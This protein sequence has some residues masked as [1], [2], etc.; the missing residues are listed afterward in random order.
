LQSW[1]PVRRVAELGSFGI[2]TIRIRNQMSA[3]EQHTEKSYAAIAYALGVARGVLSDVVDG[4]FDREDVRR[5]YEATASFR[6]AA[7]IEMKESD[8]SVN[9]NDYLSEAEKYK[10]Q[11]YQNAEDAAPNGGPATPLSNSGAVEGPPSVS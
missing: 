8:V 4:H 9:W 11:G 2:C 6:I 5:V 7:S 1:R 10:I 3:I